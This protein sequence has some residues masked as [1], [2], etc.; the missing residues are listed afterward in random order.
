MTLSLLSIST[1]IFKE[2]RKLLLPIVLPIFLS[3]IV[4]GGSRHTAYLR[5]GRED[6]SLLGRQYRGLSFSIA[7]Y[8]L[9][10]YLPSEN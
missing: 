8:G 5:F 4:S 10:E 7:Y 9:A 6:Q 1:R 3:F 2:F